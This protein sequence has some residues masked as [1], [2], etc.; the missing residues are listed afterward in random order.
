MQWHACLCLQQSWK[1]CQMGA[2]WLYMVCLLHVLRG[3]PSKPVHSLAALLGLQIQVAFE[4]THILV[5]IPNYLT[6]F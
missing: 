3:F 6:G 1:D 2:G 5:T 4:K